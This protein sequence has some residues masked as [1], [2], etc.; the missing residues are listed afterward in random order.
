MKTETNS[1]MRLAYERYLGKRVSDSHWSQIKRTLKEGGF[2]V[3]SDT[4]IFY[5][6]LR[7]SL[8][9]SSVGVLKV[10]ENYQKAEKLLAI[11]SSKIKGSEILN[12]LNA[13][14]I[15]P[16]PST[17]SRWFKRLGGF[18]KNR[19]YFPEKLTPVLTAAFLYKA[20]QSIKLGA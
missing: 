6:K 19:L 4:V 2:E 8:P 15:S 7:E 13:E 17:I 16:H 12:I 9:R 10:F 20:S 14:G 5:A 3:T 18:R 1:E 11:N